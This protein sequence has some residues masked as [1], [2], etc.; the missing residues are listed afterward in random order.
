MD[1]RAVRLGTEW[2]R[3]RMFVLSM[4]FEGSVPIKGSVTRVC[5]CVCLEYCI[6]QRRIEEDNI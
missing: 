2:R 5:V 4:M 1:L 6:R 3:T